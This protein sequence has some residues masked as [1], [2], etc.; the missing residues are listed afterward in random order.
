[1]KKNAALILSVVL[2]SGCTS[3]QPTNT[4][5]TPQ[6]SANTVGH[7]QYKTDAEQLVTAVRDAHP[8]FVVNGLLPLEYED[9]EKD[10]LKKAGKAKNITDFESAVQD[11]LASLN[12]GRT[13]ISQNSLTDS[14]IPQNLGEYTL[15]FNYG[16]RADKLYL[17]DENGELTDSEILTVGGIEASKIFSVL[18]ELF[19]CDIPAAKAD[20]RTKY[21]LDKGILALCGCDVTAPET[22]IVCSGKTF[23]AAFTDIAPQNGCAAQKTAA[24]KM[25]DDIFYADIK[26]F[27]TNDT[28]FAAVLE[29]AREYTQNGGK[30]V[31]ID[32]RENIGGSRENIALLF[33]SLGLTL[34]ASESVVRYGA[35]SE[36]AAA[37]NDSKAAKENK[38]IDLAV[39]CG[40]NTSG[41]AVGLCT[42]VKDSGIG[43]VYG[44]APHDPPCFYYKS[45]KYV[46]PNTKISVKIS[47]AYRFRPDSSNHQEIFVPN[48]IVFDGDPLQYTLEDRFKK[49]PQNTPPNSNLCDYNNECRLNR[50]LQANKN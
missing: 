3:V 2:L 26:S 24:A 44:H 43:V 34:P 40:E 49:S 17:A 14:D 27:Y 38:S 36:A 13:A 30:K 50:V 8:A 19:P 39:I 6:I 23:N 7:G 46:L 45:V 20:I 42:A 4:A 1:M 5:T 31:I 10:F 18:S 11:Y 33:D 22:E 16:A 29:Q 32:V 21:A 48:N 12:D 47:S 37:E 41:E 15:N 25:I 28:D 35:D 9:A